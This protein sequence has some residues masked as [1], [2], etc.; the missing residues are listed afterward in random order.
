MNS[1]LLKKNGKTICWKKLTQ[2]D[3]PEVEKLLEEYCGSEPLAVVLNSSDFNQ[4]SI[5]K[6]KVS[7]LQF[8]KRKK[9][10]IRL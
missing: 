9:N 1:L 5:E 2:E 10:E 8:F 7:L 6:A 3:W 4:S